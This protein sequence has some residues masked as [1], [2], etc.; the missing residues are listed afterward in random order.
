MILLAVR[1]L[2]EQAHSSSIQTLLARSASREVTLGAVYSA[3]D[4]CQRKGL[5]DS[6]LS[7]TTGPRGG[8]PKRH[9]GL[10]PDGEAALQESRRIREGLW[11][12]PALENAR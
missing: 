2:G 11:Q 9:Y 5:A 6:W 8:R 10:T 3:L 12:D 1:Q 7:E 4:R